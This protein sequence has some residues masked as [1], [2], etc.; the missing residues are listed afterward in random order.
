M[1]ASAVEP[2]TETRRGGGIPVDIGQ[3][4]LPACVLAVPFALGRVPGV[5]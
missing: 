1:V 2:A 5:P 4:V 3:D